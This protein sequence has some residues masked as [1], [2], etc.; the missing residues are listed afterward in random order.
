MIFISKILNFNNQLISNALLL[1]GEFS[2]NHYLGRN[3][4][5]LFKYKEGVIPIIISAPHAVKQVRNG[6]IKNPDIFTGSLALILAQ[7]TKCHAI[8]R[9][10]TGNGDSNSDSICSYKDYLVKKIMQYPLRCLID[11]HGLHKKRPFMIDVGTLNGKS[12]SK[13]IE[14]LIIET[15]LEEDIRDVRFNYL[16]NANKEGTVVKTIWEKTNIPSFQLEINGLYR[17][18][19]YIESWNK[20]QQIVIT[21]EKLI[22]RLN[23]TLSN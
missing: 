21:L 20:F 4:N 13:E 22:Y 18:L 6:L 12:I 8:Y 19:S 10:F 2:S 7:R 16:F 5:C 9:T 23:K 14:N 1:E 11:L 17:D 3:Y 15:F